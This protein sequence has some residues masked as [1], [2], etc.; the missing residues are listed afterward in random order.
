MSFRNVPVS[1][2]ETVTPLAQLAVTLPAIDAAV[3]AVM[4]HL[5][6]EQLPSGRPAMLDEPHAPANADAAPELEPPPDVAEPPV[7]APPPVVHRLM[8]CRLRRRFP[9]APSG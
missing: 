8:S 1:S 2:A 7:D 9:K 6:S 3:C 4:F 5:T